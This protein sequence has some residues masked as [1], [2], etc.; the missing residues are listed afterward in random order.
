M[1]E[2]RKALG[3]DGYGFSMLIVMLN[4]LGDESSLHLED[5]VEGDDELGD[6]DDVL[7]ATVILSWPAA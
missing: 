1:L 2:F 4:P 6:F 7:E 5:D 3:I